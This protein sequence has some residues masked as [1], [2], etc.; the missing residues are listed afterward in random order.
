MRS[1]FEAIYNSLYASGQ[2]LV[3]DCLRLKK[4]KIKECVNEKALSEMGGASLLFRK[5]DEEDSD[6]GEEYLR[7]YLGRIPPEFYSGISPAVTAMRQALHEQVSNLGKKDKKHKKGKKQSHLR[8]RDRSNPAAES[9]Q[10]KSASFN[11][12][13]I[14]AEKLRML[15]IFKKKDSQVSH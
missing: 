4:K 10:F 12:E 3:I 14:S 6:I 5:K 8:S 15:N 2:Q 1:E 13:G 9:S 11:A 7:T